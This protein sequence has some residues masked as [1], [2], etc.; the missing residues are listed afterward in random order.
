MRIAVGQFAAS[1]D[2]KENLGACL[3]LAAEADRGGADLLVL[4]E[5]VLAR[6]TEDR[7]RIREVAQPL[8]GPF[9]TELAAATAHGSTT[10]VVGIHEPS[11][12]G[13][14][15]NTLVVLRAGELIARYR[16]IHLYDAFGDQESANVRPADEPPVVV[17]VADTKVGLMTC[18]DVRFPELAR[19]LTDAGAEVLALPAAWVRGPAKERHWEV[20]IAARALENTCWVAA[21]GESGPRNI[22]NS[23]IVDPLG[24]VR[25][26]LATGQGLAWAEADPGVTAAARSTLPVLANRRFAVDPTVRPL[27]TLPLGT[28]P[29]GA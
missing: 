6:F 23:L 25:S 11:D 21:S 12:D 29:L 18:Y 13:R 22:G 24:T 15:F 2:W 17:E 28:L 20:M 5:G 10:I 4:P 16:K 19:L 26:R 3:D 27:G 14:V 8:D 1:P 7:H 9:V